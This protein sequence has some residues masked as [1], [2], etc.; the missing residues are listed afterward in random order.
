MIK[1]DN[2]TSVTVQLVVRQNWGSYSAFLFL[3]FLLQ[4]NIVMV[5]QHFLN[6]MKYGIFYRS[7]LKTWN[8]W[9]WFQSHRLNSATLQIIQDAG[10]HTPDPT[11]ID[12]WDFSV[13]ESGFFPS[14]AFVILVQVIIDAEA[15]CVILNLPS[16]Y[17]SEQQILCTKHLLCKTQ[18]ICF[19]K[20]VWGICGEFSARTWFGTHVESDFTDQCSTHSLCQQ[21]GA[22]NASILP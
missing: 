15:S 22:Q 6:V 7:K 18:G 4:L 10:H 16:D 20:H 12:W 21:Q 8:I 17:I 5:F 1:E 19:Q 9:F 3:V 14:R 11:D 13:D 2:K